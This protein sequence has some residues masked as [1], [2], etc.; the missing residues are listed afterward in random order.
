MTGS[1]PLTKLF[2][3][4]LLLFLTIPVQNHAQ[5]NTYNDDETR[6]VIV[7]FANHTTKSKR[8][9]ISEQVKAVLIKRF[10]DTDTELW[11]IPFIVEIN[12]RTYEGLNTISDYV[13]G[14]P[15]IQYIEPNHSIV[16]FNAPNDPFFN[17]LWGLHNTGQLAGLSGADI[18]ILQAWEITTGSESTTVGVL[19]TGIDWTHEDLAENIWQNLDEDADGD[20]KVI[21]WNGSQWVMDEG[22]LNGV[23]DD[24]NGYVDDIIGWDFVNNDNNPYDDNGHGTH[25]SGTIGARGNNDKG[26]TGVAQQ[27][28]LMPLKIFDGSG[29]GNIA[30]AKEAMEYA[31]ANGADI[32]NISW[33]TTQDSETMY[34]AFENAQN[35]D[36][37]VVAAAG[38]NDR[39]NDIVP[40]YPASYDFENI[41]A[42]AAINRHNSL[43]IFSNYGETSVDIGAPGGDIFSTLPGNFYGWYSGTSM[44]TPHI[45]GALALALSACN[46]TA[47]AEIKNHLLN[48]ATSLNTPNNRGVSVLNVH[49]FLQEVT[50][51]NAEF[52]YTT[53]GLE[54]EFT[55]ESEEEGFTYEWNFGDS[56][57][58]SLSE[59]E[60][61]YEY[62]ESDH[63]TVC[64]TIS[65]TCGYSTS[66]QNIF[67]NVDNIQPDCAPEWQQF[68]NGDNILAIAEQ[69]DYIWA[70]GKGGLAKI[71]RIDGTST[72]FTNNNSGLPHNHINSIT[73]DANGTKWIGTKSGLVKFDGTNWVTYDT[74]NSGLPA[75]DVQSVAITPVGGLRIIATNGGGVAL[76]NGES[77]WIILNT[78]NAMLLS[79]EI[80]DV[81]VDN[82]SIIFAATPNGVMKLGTNGFVDLE[83]GTVAPGYDIVN[84]IAI[85]PVSGNVWAAT[86]GGVARYDGNTWEAINTGLAGEPISIDVNSEGTQWVGTNSGAYSLINNTT[87]LPEY[88]NLG[89]ESGQEINAVLVV[90][91]EEVWFGTNRSLKKLVEGEWSALDQLNSPL[92]ANTIHAF[93]EDNIGNMWIG[94]SDGLIQLAGDEWIQHPEF[95]NEAVSALYFNDDKLWVGTDLRVG[96]INVVEDIN[97][98]TFYPPLN[99]K[100]TSI[101]ADQDGQVWAGTQSAGIA[102]LDDNNWIIHNTGNSSLPD[103][104][105]HTI[106]PDAITGI[107]IATSNGLANLGGNGW[108]VYDSPTADNSVTGLAIDSDGVVWLTTSDHLARIDDTNTWSIE[109]IAYS[110]KGIQGLLIDGYNSKW[111]STEEGFCKYDG[112]SCTIY[113]VA[114]SPLANDNVQ[115]IRQDVGGCYWIGTDGGVSIL[116]ALTASFAYDNQLPCS[117]TIIPM[118]NSSTGALEQNWYVNDVY[119]SSDKDYTHDFTEPGTYEVKLITTN[120]EN[121]TATFI[122]EITIGDLAEDISLEPAINVCD[123]IALLEANLENMQNYRWYKEG[124]MLSNTRE[125]TAIESGDYIL[126]VQD[127]CDNWSSSTISVILSA[128]CIWPGDTDDNGIVNAVD[129]LSIGIALGSS[130]PARADSGEW[131]GQANPNWPDENLAYADANGDGVVDST[132]LEIVFANYGQTHGEAGLGL[133]SVI[134]PGSGFGGSGYIADTPPDAYLCLIP[135]ENSLFNEDYDI[136]FN[137]E[138]TEEIGVSLESYGIAYTIKHDG[139]VANTDFSSA[140]LK[141]NGTFNEM[142]TFEQNSPG[143]LDVA[144][145]R[146]DQNNIIGDGDVAEIIFEEDFPSGEVASSGLEDEHTA[147]YSVEN[148]TLTDKDGIVIPVEGHTLVISHPGTDEQGNVAPIALS[149]KG[150]AVT[151]YGEGSAEITVHRGTAPFTYEWD[152]GETTPTVANLSPGLHYLTVTDAAGETIT[153]MAYIEDHTGIYIDYEVT[154]E[155]DGSEN[156]SI[157]LTPSGSNNFTYEWSSG[158]TSASVAGLQAGTYTVTI[159]ND[160]G[161]QKVENIVVPGRLCVK[162]KFILEGAFDPATGLMRGD[163][164]FRGF[165]PLVSPYQTGESVSVNAFTALDPSDV[166]VDW[167]VVELRDKNSVKLVARQPAF[168]Q[169]DGDVISLDGTD[170]VKFDDL[171]EDNYYITVRH[172]NHFTLVSANAPFIGREPV[173]QDFT[174]SPIVSY[175]NYELPEVASGIYA[176][177]AGNAADD[178]LETREDI[179]G[180]D[181][182]RWSNNN[183]EFGVYSTRDFTLDGDTNGADRIIWE[184]NNGFFNQLPD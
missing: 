64:L 9:E 175:P 61:E 41:I 159:T 121:C 85:E 93:A 22:D 55:A 118:R 137:V 183:G 152:N 113:N 126:E 132:D 107:W 21:E 140:W 106:V 160:E 27:V 6:E 147:I 173:I 20:G 73:V 95:T 105:I 179:N 62:N 120:N 40:V 57:T 89:I 26:I 16:I 80:I 49:K 79:D 167:V 59:N 133:S 151:C 114:N 33:G 171:P 30:T 163:L 143:R 19:D 82:Q 125:F 100:I 71:N 139:E 65:N 8:R 94:T 69:G 142:L 43:T 145:S 130:G 116:S 169:R 48:T 148:I 136:L 38:N 124:E 24:G 23:D 47:P 29:V 170:G 15:G 45:T 157:N 134:F 76:F 4:G 109:N 37:L 56:A 77:N 5:Q 108:I 7:K 44:A 172:R 75:N 2:V 156:G 66:C 127:W 184:P 98:I 150:R 123:D 88:D 104:N 72:F 17:R 180:D 1:Y 101:I 39:D 78:A 86:Q 131:Q 51:P 177:H 117:N 176:A 155:T 52:V 34:E 18:S 122:E 81:V 164:Q 91:N 36:Q 153:G 161:C 103:N 87:W 129:A 154:A 13:K 96:E 68:T 31:L 182:V 112:Y 84:D 115:V 35:N 141:G 25:V 90:E 12:G 83:I 67:V 28:A 128:R 165:L 168:L 58:Q 181:K 92:S 102:K 10:E 74:Q 70:G 97:D 11:R 14:H 162:P 135:D 174:Q 158:Q 166:V 119:V 3:F 149:I 53:D 54:V 32:T 60:V 99:D 63:Y 146:E 178:V 144:Q 50:R 111:L 110:P 46:S 42:V 138:L